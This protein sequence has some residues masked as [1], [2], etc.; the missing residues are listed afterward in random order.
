M[1]AKTDSV[2][3]IGKAPKSRGIKK[4]KKL[5][6]KLATNLLDSEYIPEKVDPSTR[7][8]NTLDKNPD[9]HEAKTL[10]TLVN[11]FLEDPIGAI[12]KRNLAKDKT[13]AFSIKNLPYYQAISIL[14][15]FWKTLTQKRF[16]MLTC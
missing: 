10:E 5:I 12:T 14:K 3:F 2:S 1:N 9:D 7:P 4:T 11:N 8:T 6:V 15:R 13:K 16:N